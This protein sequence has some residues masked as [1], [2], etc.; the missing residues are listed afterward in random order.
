[1]HK[2][3]QI[4]LAWELHL[5]EVPI[6][7]ISSRIGVDRV[8][9]YRWLAGIRR[10]GSLTMFL[11][12]YLNSKKGSR[13]GRKIDARVKRWIWDYRENYHDICAQKIKTFLED[14]H[15]TCLSPT[16]I[17]KVL[18]ERYQIR[19]KWKRNH[20][21]G[22]TP[23]AEKPRQVV[24]MDSVDFGDIYAFTGVDIF[25]KEVYVYLTTALTSRE[26]AYFLEESMRERFDGFS[27]IAQTDGGPEFK[28][29]FH[30]LT[31]SYTNWHRIARPYR[32]NEQ[33]YIESFNRSLRKECLGWSN[34][35][36][37]DLGRLRTHLTNY[38]NY[39]HFK[40]PHLSLNMKT[41]SKFL[42]DYRMLHI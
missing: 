4:T 31:P 21:R 5:E 36:S 27:E 13:R 29:E 25:S 28:G 23:S 35:R 8:T 22:V 40:R 30:D 9:I 12:A 15:Q 42:E 38:L 32:K 10:T 33:S 3:T 18:S 16:T 11:E 26:G 1:M 20:P 17:Y 14:D 24:Q 39:Y 7:H 6:T 41:P 34:Y 37:D 2:L 19:S